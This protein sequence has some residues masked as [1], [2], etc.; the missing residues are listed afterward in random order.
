MT[1]L[2]T[3]ATTALSSVV[4]FCLGGVVAGLGLGVIAL[5]ALFALAI[6]GIA[7]LAAPFVALAQPRTADADAQTAA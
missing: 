1:N 7:F 5:L 3:K 4:L 2:I 6:A